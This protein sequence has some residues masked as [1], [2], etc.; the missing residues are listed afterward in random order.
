VGA[1][2]LA[3]LVLLAAAWGLAFVFIRVAVVPL[4]PPALVELRQLIAGAVLLLYLRWLG[5][6]LDLQRQW[7]K[8]LAL[9]VLSAALP[10]TLIA[11]A[12]QVLTAS[13][14]VILVST[15]PLVAALL[16]AGVL[17]EPLTARKL[18]GLVL[19]IAG[20][21][22][23]V[24]WNPAGEPIPPAWTIACVL[25]AAVLYAI[26]GVYTRVATRGLA[27]MAT[28]AGSQL[29]AAALLAPFVVAV[30]PARF[31]TPVEWLCVVA[32]ALL[33]SA[34]AFVLY[35]QLIRNVGPVKTLTVNFLTPLFGVGGG[36]LLL[37][38]RITANVI[39]GTVVILA[40]TAL[41]L[42]TGGPQPAPPDE[43]R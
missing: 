22:L 2:D 27:P 8:Y 39:A 28:A 3:R 31:P 15:S 10:F 23:L 37:G 43:T 5:Q 25:A 13:Y 1:A 38:E 34:A 33:S 42:W 4:G 16:A 24:G 29:V 41:V 36:A 12:Q 26:A 6:P 20:V 21:A 7:R 19:G 35:F 18:G 11:A 9:A 17:G 40:A 14:T 30:P 32:L